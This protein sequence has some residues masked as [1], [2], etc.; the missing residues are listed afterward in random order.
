VLVPFGRRRIIGYVVGV[1]DHVK[2]GLKIKEII[3][4]LDEE[5]VISNEMLRLTKWIADYYFSSW[6]EV[7][8]AAL[9]NMDIRPR[10]KRYVRLKEET[11]DEGVIE[12]LIQRAPRQA[13][14]LRILKDGEIV[15]TDLRKRVICRPSSLRSLE[16]KGIITI[17]NKEIM[18]IPHGYSD[19]QSHLSI[20][21]P[22]EEDAL[23]LKLKDHS[24]EETLVPTQSAQRGR[25]IGSP[26]PPSPLWGE[27][28]GEGVFAEGWK[29]LD[30][31]QKNVLERITKRISEGQFTTFLL[32]G[33]TGSGKTEIYA[34]SIAK[35][36]EVKKEAIFL[37]PEIS[38]TPQLVWRFKALFGDR[39]ALLHS[40]ISP[41]ERY[42]EWRRIKSRGADIVVGARSAIFAP[43]ERIGVI[44]VDEEHDTSYK[45]DE[46]PRYNARDVAVV[47][48]RIS[49][50][51][52]ILGS[53][54]PSIEAFYNSRIGRYEYLSLP[55]RVGKRAM[56]RVEVVDMKKEGNKR[57]V[58]S[59][60]LKEAIEDRLLKGEQTFLF[61]NRR[62]TASFLQCRECGFVLMCPNC[63]LSLTYHG[64]IK[65]ML[66]HYCNYSISAPSMCPDCNG[67]RIDRFGIGTQELEERVK[68]LFPT[69]VVARMD[70]DT[71]RVRDGYVE[72]L[73]RL[74]RGEIDILIGTQMIAKG[75]DFPLVT[76]VG[77][78]HAD[79]SLNI[80]DFR[81]GERTFQLITQVAGRSG[82]GDREG[83]VIIQTYHP[84]HYIIQYASSYDFNEF[85]KGEI[86][87][88]EDLNYPPF[89]KMIGIMIE[90]D[91]EK[92]V[93][94]ISNEL[95][96]IIERGIKSHNSR[97]PKGKDGIIV[98]MLG[99]AR[100]FIYKIRNRYRRQII[101]KG[102]EIGPLRS[103]LYNGMEYLDKSK[104]GGVR[105]N[106][107]VDPVHLV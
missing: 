74:R 69:A 13:D 4:L 26:P 91:K 3:N 83:E 31:N 93:E 28:K 107:D 49:G 77:V 68:G 73:K 100:A 79:A 82:R 95:G 7:I 23:I 57:E 10:V 38:L 72:I 92:I 21:P 84:H 104:R 11:I 65:R 76:L 1:S 41:G 37:V 56:P 78:I 42:D 2:E 54:T 9:P 12:S 71:T 36:L 62:G 20:I 35:A 34:R 53:A 19:I 75:H 48:G 60:R 52:V 81:S 24:Q 14:I 90:S 86:T 40:G 67:Y 94:K 98:E 101:L 63:S 17:Y 30:A 8:K 43:F 39:I 29:D 97:R 51:V 15:L 5:D 58:F 85:Y 59:Q 18:R 103:V 64:K 45:Q 70:R 33:I 27:G 105:I 47:R 6:G 96:K 102:K 88:R 89:V 55:E 106:I 22:D 50:A 80:P 44:I 61:L 87:F 32:H 25:R 66:C 16:D 46:S 99:P